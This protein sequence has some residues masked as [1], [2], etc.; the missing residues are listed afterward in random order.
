[1][2]ETAIPLYQTKQ[3]FYVP[4]YEI[5]L[6]DRRLQDD[7][8]HDVTQVSYKDS[9]DSIDSCEIVVNNELQDRRNANAFKYSDSDLFNPGQNIELTMGYYGSDDQRMMLRGEIVSL[10]PSFP[11]SGQSTLSISALNLLHRFRTKQESFMYENQTDSQIAEQIGSRLQVRMETKPSSSETTYPYLI[12]DNQYDILFLMERAR[13]IGYDLFVVEE[14]SEP[15]LYFGPSQDLKRNT[16]ELKYGRSLM[17]FTPNLTTAG[18]VGKVTVQSWDPVNKKQIKQTVTRSEVGEAGSFE[19]K[20]TGAFGEREEVI[21]N[22]PVTTDAEARELA[23]ET[24]RQNVK[25][26][27]KGSGSVIGLPDLRA[28]SVLMLTGLGERFSGRYF[29][30]S[31]THSIGGS[32]YTTSFQCRREDA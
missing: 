1:M 27:V 31:T 5:R 7:V 2:V 20:F 18:Q 10:K 8:V 22:I 17:Q 3:D 21:S 24:L 23:T 26:F 11:S 19:A 29:V 13:R 9:L 15:T 32:G 14:S 25:E 6:E 30:T 4:F 12:Q 28:G 16:Y